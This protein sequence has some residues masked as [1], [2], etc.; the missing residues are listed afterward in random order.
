MKTV[1]KR[2]LI[3]FMLLLLALVLSTCISARE[4]DVGIPVEEYPELFVQRTMPTHGNG[5]IAV[6]LIQFPD[7]KNDK[8]DA[9]AEY[10]NE[11]YFSEK[12]LAEKTNEENYPWYGSVSTFYR[13]QSYGK[14]NLSGQVFD[15]YTAKHERSYYNS[16]P[17]KKELVME[18]IAHY[19][20][21][22][23]DF[24]QFDGD[25]NG[26][27]DAVIY[28]F[29]GP[30][31]GGQSLPWYGGMEYTTYV[32]QTKSGQ[33]INS[34]IQLDN[35]VDK[36]DYNSVRLRQIICHELL[37]TLD[38]NDLYGIGWYPNL[39]P[40]EDLMCNNTFTINPYYKI[41]LGWTEKI[42]LVTS[43]TLDIQLNIWEKSG[44]TILVTDQYNG[45]FDEFY[46]IA[47]ARDQA[48]GKPQVRIWHIDARLN[49]EKTGFLY[50]N[51]TYSPIPWEKRPHVTVTEFSKHLF[52]EEVSSKAYSDHVLNWTNSLYFREGSIL[53][54]NSIPSTDTHDGRHTGIKIDD[55]KVFGTHASMDITF[56]HKD[57]ASP[58][59]SDTHSVI[60][61]TP[62]NKLIFNEYIYPADNWNKIQL[63]TLTGEVIPARITRSHYLVYEIEI[64]IEGD[65]PK[66]GYHIVLP[67][68]CVRD[69]SGNKNK[70]I[71]IPVLPKG[72]VFEET[73]TLIPWYSPDT[74]RVGIQPVYSFSYGN[75][76]V[77]LTASAEKANTIDFVEFL[78]LDANGKK[79]IHTFVQNPY[80]G[81]HQLYA[82]YQ[83]NDGSY[84]LVIRGIFGSCNI[85]LCI[86]KNG[87]LRWHKAGEKMELGHIFSP[88]TAY[89]NGIL[90]CG[91]WRTFI[92]VQ[93]GEITETRG[94]G[95][96]LLNVCYN[97]KDL[98]GVTSSVP[99]YI[100]VMDPATLKI[101]EQYPFPI[102]MNSGYYDFLL[103][104]NANG[105]YTV[106]INS[107]SAKGCAAL[108]DSSFRLIKQVSID[109]IAVTI[110]SSCRI[111]PNDGILVAI[112][113]LNGEFTN[114]ILSVI[115]LDKNLNL[116]WETE[117]EAI[118]A[119]FFVTT[120]NEIGAFA[121]C[122]MP[123]NEACLL[124]YGSEN[125]FETTSHLTVHQPSC[126]STCT[127]AGQREHWICLDCGGYFSDAE[128]KTEIAASS[129]VIPKIAHKAVPYA[130]VAPTCTKDGSAGGTYCSVCRSTLTSKTVIKA[131]GHTEVKEPDTAP[132]CTA[133]G[134][135]GA[136]YCSV[137]REELAPKTFVKATGHTEVKEADVPP[138]CTVD[139]IIGGTHCSVCGVELTPKTVLKATGHTE[140]EDPA[141]AP[142]Y[143]REGLTAG[144]HCSVCHEV[145][146]KQQPVERLKP[147]SSE[148]DTAPLSE[149]PKPT[150]PTEVT[151]LSTE[152]TG[153]PAPENDASLS[154]SNSVIIII[155]AVTLIGVSA[156]TLLLLKKRR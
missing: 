69:S 50:D 32:G 105:T 26:E 154:L 114:S 94:N 24:S 10:Y 8:A 45:I 99:I 85:L 1:S 141:V 18:A 27:L 128:G 144:V 21:K 44:E 82:V 101:K 64:I 135:T 37:H 42:A 130:D 23:V 31:D 143:E 97:G 140:A 155:A 41:L 152:T 123:K 40:T 56:G 131:T 78:K 15:W 98:V 115:R 133:D 14:L 73:R 49:A 5:K 7:H 83:A 109:A 93:T 134:A 12:R 6:F 139:G 33:K 75:E 126:A 79:T 51:L 149:K 100:A 132:T 48:Y 11:L 67:E 3:P 122:L 106:L 145:L 28:H 112:R 120:S 70:A 20:A 72:H 39:A 156:A 96:S 127:K 129:V 65:L 91:Q 38:M 81:N 71:T 76:T 63:T 137:C 58:V 151:E 59:I 110:H 113:T 19:E 25:R 77:I 74:V 121:F 118:T 57:T 35:S 46:L 136:T 29:T 17:K 150:D 52:I 86:D 107:R 116:M 47:Y 117:L 84:V 34:F 108:L 13:E 119:S 88:A 80:E 9:T 61:F 53:G 103:E 104:Y 66:E 2:I 142:T 146:V 102:D 95:R 89:E 62:E 125:S 153:Q 30:V 90:F 148:P 87:E 16:D 55:F 60:G 22:G 4:L 92:D 36:S 68:G 43:D 138:T 111:L 54:P 124:S 147:E